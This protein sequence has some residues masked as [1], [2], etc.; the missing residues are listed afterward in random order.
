[1]RRQYE[2]D[3]FLELLENNNFTF[4]EIASGEEVLK[5]IRR[6]YFSRI[7]IDTDTRYEDSTPTTASE[8]FTDMYAEFVNR[9]LANFTRL[10]DML[11]QEYN[12]LENYDRIEEG[13]KVTTSVYGEKV[14]TT[15]DTKRNESISTPRLQITTENYVVAYNESN[16]VLTGKTVSIPNGSDEVNDTIVSQNSGGETYTEDERTDTVTVGNN[17]F[18]IHGNIGITTPVQMILGE[19]GLRERID[20]V[21][22]IVKEFVD[23]VSFYC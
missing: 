7:F 11:L 9:R 23:E 8:C 16:P 5:M 2:I 19:L 14:T 21:K 17:N 12:P 13:E 3:D 18:R 22:I 4:G 15:E 1:M 20:L 10:Y 6:N